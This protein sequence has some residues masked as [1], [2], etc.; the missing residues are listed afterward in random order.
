MLATVLATGGCSWGGGRSVRLDSVTNPTRLRVEMTLQAYTS[1][2]ANSADVYMTDLPAT[3]LEP[4]ADL[5]GLSGNITHL[6]MF[7]DPDPGRT[8]IDPTACSVTVRHIV[9]ANGE[10]GVYGGG[11]FTNPGSPGDSTFSGTVRGATLRLVAASPG[12]RDLLGATEFEGG[13]SA[14]KDAKLAR[15][16]EARFRSLLP[17]P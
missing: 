14:K 11:G 7:I 12:F 4:N 17:A 9:I 8:P 5:S 16:L 15:R 3:V 1:T 6:R 13:F 2:D 10:V